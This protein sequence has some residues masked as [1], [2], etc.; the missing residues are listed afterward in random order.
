[1]SERVSKVGSLLQVAGWFERRATVRPQV[2]PRLPG[3][4]TIDC[5]C[6]MKRCSH[7]SVTAQGPTAV[8]GAEGTADCRHQT[9]RDSRVRT[10][11]APAEV[12][13]A[14][15]WQPTSSLIRQL[16]W[17][18][19]ETGSL[20][21]GRVQAPCAPV[22]ERATPTHNQTKYIFDCHQMSAII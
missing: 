19:D 16:Q 5:R 6:T 22:D 3:T 17:P 13:Q 18:R 20:V 14:T 8:S 15:S 12:D 11:C 4:A 1:M 21:V 7:A 9:A 10:G 2:T